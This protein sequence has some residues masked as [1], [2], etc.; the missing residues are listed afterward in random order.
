MLRCVALVRTDV[1]QERRASIIRV[2]RIGELGTPL[3]VTS[4]RRNAAKKYYA[5]V[6]PSSQILVTLM[7]E[8]LLSSETSV[9]TRS[10]RHNIP[11]DYILQGIPTLYENLSSSTTHL[12][13]ET[14]H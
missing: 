5:N 12:L 11:E 3:A 2:P 13:N 1:S 6:V 10:I 9:L 7:T 14:R 4:N 8:K